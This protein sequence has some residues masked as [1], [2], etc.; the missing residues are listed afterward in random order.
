V[1]PGASQIGIA[2]NHALP[3]ERYREGQICRRGRFTFP[4]D[5]ARHEERSRS[6]IGMGAP[7]S[8]SQDTIGLSVIVDL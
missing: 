6:P 1:N 5:G 8:G 4:G 2:E 3:G 7:D